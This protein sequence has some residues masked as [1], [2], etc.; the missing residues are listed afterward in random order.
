[1]IDEELAEHLHSGLFHLEFAREMLLRTGNVEAFDRWPWQWGNEVYTGVPDAQVLEENVNT[2]L[3]M[4]E[5]R[6]TADVSPVEYLNDRRAE[7]WRALLHP[8][9][10]RAESEK[11]MPVT[12]PDFACALTI[13]SPD[14]AVLKRYRAGMALLLPALDL[15]FHD[16]DPELPPYSWPGGRWIPPE[17]EPPAPNF[18][19]L[20]DSFNGHPPDTIYNLTRR[21]V[22]VW[23][24]EGRRG[25]AALATATAPGS[26]STF[27]RR[28]TFGGRNR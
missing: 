20:V 10:R 5:P 22:D 2:A 17:R 19:I 24:R 27:T 25:A 28:T 15:F 18:V 7:W 16:P 13:S 4:T 14:A 9:G 3:K 11:E 12:E 26:A 21:L 23:E 1:M 6:L 8:D